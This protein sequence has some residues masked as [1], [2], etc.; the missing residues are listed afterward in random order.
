LRGEAEAKPASDRILER[1]AAPQPAAPAPAP[2]PQPDE[3]L[4]RQKLEALT[5]PAEPVAPAPSAAPAAARPVSEAELRK[6]DEKLA[7]LVRK[8]NE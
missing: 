4:S 7:S 2:A 8:Q 1:L 3:T 6:A 5:K